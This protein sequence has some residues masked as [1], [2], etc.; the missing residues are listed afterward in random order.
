M[1]KDKVRDKNMQR[2]VI[3]IFKERYE[4]I[5][6]LVEKKNFIDNISVT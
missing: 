3:D 6:I 1:F 5:T 2:L 4:Q